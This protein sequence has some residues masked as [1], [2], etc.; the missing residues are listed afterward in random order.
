MNNDRVT[1]LR[2]LA[3]IS[4]GSVLC[5]AALNGIILPHQFISDGVT[6]L[7]L[8]VHYL[9]PGLPVS[10]IYLVLNLPIFAAGWKYVGRRF[11]G[12]SLAGMFIFTLCLQLVNINIPVQDQILS[13]I[14]GGIITGLGSGII[15][16]SLGSAGGSSILSVILLKRYSVSIGNSTLAFN[17]ILLSLAAFLFSVDSALY[18]LVYIYVTAKITDL[19][20]TGLSRRKT[21]QIISDRWEEIAEFI[22]NRQKRGLTL[23]DVTGAYHKRE[24]KMLYVVVLLRELPQLKHMILDID[25]NAFV[26]VSDTM[27]VIG[28]RIGNQP[29]W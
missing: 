17:V 5:A 6:G 3:L 7:S 24:K 19:V 15:L 10:M 4:A 14:L 20:I 12:Y 29:H 22:L 27:E 26:V 28:E 1:I 18:T 2:S 8:I 23:I 9:F 16:R 25:P 21:V 11:L 13:A